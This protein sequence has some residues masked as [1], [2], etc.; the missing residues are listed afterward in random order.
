MDIF[1]AMKRIIGKSILFALTGVLAVFSSCQKE[2]TLENSITNAGGSNSAVT[3]DFRAKVNGVQFVANLS[4]TANR[5]NGLIN[6]TGLATDGQLI[7]ITLFDS[8]VHNYTL[9]Q[10]SMGVIAYSE[11]QNASTISYASNGSSNP[12]EAG[13][14]CN[15]TSI[16]PVT[17]K[18]SGTFSV[19]VFR[20]SDNSSKNITEGV[21][22]NITYSTTIGVPPTAAT[23]TFRVKLDGV[24][25]TNYSVIGTLVPVMD[26]IAI[27]SNY[28]AAGT[29]NIGLVFSKTIVPGAYP[30]DI[31]SVTGIYNPTNSITNPTP[32]AAD[33]GTLTILEHNT[34]TK[35]IR[36]TFNFSASPFGVGSGGPI[37]F[38][39]GYF[40]VIYH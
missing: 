39:E 20:Q 27:T 30:F 5:V 21:F 24:S 19:K 12:A 33:S 25:W 23:D 9:N 7:T 2:L 37:S 15:I 1:D 11:S 35:R 29:K 13:G 36:G 38:T 26:N 40:S 31:V 18:I 14:S 8:G 6:I 17:K 10:T 22:N 28:D 16:D 34:T 3:G 32:Y 4:A